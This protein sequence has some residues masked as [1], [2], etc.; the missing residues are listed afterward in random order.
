MQEH[1]HLLLNAAPAP[2]LFGTVVLLCGYLV[3]VALHDKVR[4][5][6]KPCEF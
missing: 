3:F 1:V 5:N 4:L 6:S 2:S